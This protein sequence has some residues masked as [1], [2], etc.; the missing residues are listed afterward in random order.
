MKNIKK[1]ISAKT[2]PSHYMM[3]KYW[4]RK[5]HNVVSDYILNFTKPG[6]TVL[7]PFMGSGVVIIES[8]KKGRKAIGV[9]L[10]PMACFITRNTINKIDIDDFEKEFNTIYLKNYEK[11]KEIYSTKCPTCKAQT[12]F[13]NSI[14]DH[15][16]FNKIRATCEKCGKFIKKVD[17]YDLNVLKKS[18]ETFSILDN[19]GKIFFPRD[20]IL[21]FVKRNG[22]SRLNEFFTPRSL[23]VLGSLIKDINKIKNENT[24]NLILLC[25]TSM[26]PNVSKMIPGNPETVNG[27]SGWVISKLWAPKVHTEKNVFFSFKHRFQKILKGKLEINNLFDPKNAQIHNIDSANLKKLKSESIDYIFTDPPY[28]DSIAYFGLSMFWNAWLENTVDYKN[29]IIYD[30]YRDKKY[31]DYSSRM[32][33][34]Y[35]EMYRVL[36]DEKYL[37]FT[38]HNRNLNIWKAVMD[39]VTEAGFHLVNVVYQ[40]QAV[41]SG[42][43]GINKDNTLRGDFVYNFMK[44][45][46][47]K[48]K[49]KIFD[50]VDGKKEIIKK[51]QSWIK[52]NDGHISSDLLYEKLIPFIVEGNLYKDNDKV[53]NIDDILSKSFI[54]KKNISQVYGWQEK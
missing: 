24:K 9:D 3:H 46:S 47:K 12:F 48:N 16:Q 15:D 38:F 6:D 29:E 32:K 42:T 49:K 2:H 30:P 7:D 37:S 5:P 45:T 17:K 44:D 40:E 39:A 14:W 11:F 54:Y 28:G 36:K 31:E 13:E 33:R 53:M 22:K 34:V 52:N 26:L 41:S 1:N 25:F 8:L 50:K 51:I 4:G 19:Q 18:I 21:K 20:E 35:A 43:Q 23:V 10:N 27:K